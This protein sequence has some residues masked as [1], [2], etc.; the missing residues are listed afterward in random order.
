M[1]LPWTSTTPTTRT[2]TVTTGTTT[3]SP[4]HLHNPCRRYGQPDDIKL[5]KT[6]DR[7]HDITSPCTTTAQRSL[8]SHHSDA[9]NCNED[10]RNDG[11]RTDD[12]IMTTPYPTTSSQYT[13]VGGRSNPL[14]HRR[15][16]SQPPRLA[17]G[18]TY[19]LP[20]ISLGPDASRYFLL[21]PTSRR[22][23]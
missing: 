21:V 20:V 17:R 8:Q 4:T 22:D 1:R 2:M 7:A 11:P 5:S 10:H 15:L 3:L 16:P 12:N 18:R 6:H 9:S 23:N 19:A 14:C 13:T